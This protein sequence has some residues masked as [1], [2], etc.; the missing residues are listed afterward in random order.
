MF[1][2]KKRL[3]F[4]PPG[5]LRSGE[6]WEVN[7]EGTDQFLSIMLRVMHPFSRYYP[8]SCSAVHPLKYHVPG[9]FGSTLAGR[10]PRLQ[11]AAICKCLPRS[12]DEPD[13]PLAAFTPAGQAQGE[14]TTL[15]RFLG[16]VIG[17]THISITPVHREVITEVQPR[18]AA[19]DDNPEE[20]AHLAGR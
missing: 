18:S 6:A 15:G 17:L 4:M 16:A 8:G 12:S 11:S 19:L 1:S 13:L 7:E 3:K 14:E 10:A 20:T 2:F 9:L 5:S